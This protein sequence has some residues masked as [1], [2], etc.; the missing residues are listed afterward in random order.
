MAKHIQTAGRVDIGRHASSVER[1]NDTQQ[2]LESTVRDT[3]LG[4]KR[5]IVEDGSAGRFRTR[6]CGGR[7]CR[8]SCLDEWKNIYCYVSCITS[9][10]WL[11][12]LFDWQALSDRR[13]YEIQEIG[14]RVGEV[15]TGS[16]GGVN[17]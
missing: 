8:F 10:Q 2:G 4:M 12:R 13:I 5:L 17:D 11:E 6:T 15:Q 3:G 16:L 9:N 1:I 14:F 7:H